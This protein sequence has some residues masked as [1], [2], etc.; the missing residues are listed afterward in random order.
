HC[1]EAKTQAPSEAC[2]LVTELDVPVSCRQHHTSH[3]VIDAQNGHGCSLQIRLP[4]AIPKIRQHEQTGSFHLCGDFEPSGN[5]LVQVGGAAT[6][7]GQRAGFFNKSHTG[8]VEVI[9]SHVLQLSRVVQ[10]AFDSLRNKHAI[11][12]VV[13]LE[14]EIIEVL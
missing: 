8:R 7:G 1:D 11:K 13:I 9:S 14:D 4:A 5:L 10:Q 6:L 2:G 12:R 3:R